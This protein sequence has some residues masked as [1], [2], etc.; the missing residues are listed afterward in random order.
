MG[1][2]AIS[3]YQIKKAKKPNSGKVWHIVGRPNGKRIRAWFG[4][5][6][7]AQAEA[8]ERNVAMRKLWSGRRV[9]RRG[10]RG[11]RQGRR[12]TAKTVWENAEG[13]NRLLLT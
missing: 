4:T 9:L 12:N 10:T 3:E 13:R 7:A 8:T 11:D 6:E 1:R 5:K 2:P